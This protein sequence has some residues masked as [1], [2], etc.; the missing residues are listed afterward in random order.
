MIPCIS[1]PVGIIS[2]DE[3]FSFSQKQNFSH[4]QCCD[5]L[6]LRIDSIYS[7]Q[8]YASVCYSVIIEIIGSC[9]LVQTVFN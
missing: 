5:I 2:L 9:L 3:C 1:D 7:F 8:F 6:F 4:H